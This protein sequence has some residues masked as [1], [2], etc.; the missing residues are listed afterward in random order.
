MRQREC[1]K[2]GADISESYTS[3]DPDVGIMSSGWWCEA[4]DEHVL[5]DNDDSDIWED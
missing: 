1:P 4:C 2:C 3:Y 5:D